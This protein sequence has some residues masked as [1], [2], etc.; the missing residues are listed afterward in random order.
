M[1]KRNVT[2]ITDPGHGWLSVPLGD[3]VELGIADQITRCS[4]ISPTR[5]YLEEDV[6]AGT[7]LKAAEAAGWEIRQRVTYNDNGWKGRNWPSYCAHWAY[8]PL[9]HGSRVTLADGT[10]AR[11]FNGADGRFVIITEDGRY[12]RPRKSNALIGLY[13]PKGEVTNYDRDE[14]ELVSSR[15]PLGETHPIC[16]RPQVVLG[17]EY[18]RPAVWKVTKAQEVVHG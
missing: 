11:Y 1:K 12:Y 5:A 13:P 2:A 9:R 4:Y 14:I 18:V 3:L 7:Y 17:C 10:E 15:N 8:H 16:G 6:D